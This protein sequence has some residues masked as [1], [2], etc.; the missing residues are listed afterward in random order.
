M[1][2][3]TPSLSSVDLESLPRSELPIHPIYPVSRTFRHH[4]PAHTLHACRCTL[5]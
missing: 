2:T 1:E 3:M 4:A 5:H